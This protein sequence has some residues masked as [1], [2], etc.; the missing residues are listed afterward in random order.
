[1]LGTAAVAAGC[2]VAPSAGTVGRARVL[3]V[4]MVLVMAAT[5]LAVTPEV[6][7]VGGTLLLAL[8]AALLTGGA[9]GPREADVHRAV[10]AVVMALAILLQRHASMAGMDHGH[11][12]VDLGLRATTA[13]YLC[14]TGVTLVR[15]RGAALLRWEHTA[16]AACV[17]VMVAG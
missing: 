8:A 6:R 9:S 4:G 12:A 1:M 16:M 15:R 13:A 10:G 11:D 7:F 5:T 17:A 2:C 3:A 14:W